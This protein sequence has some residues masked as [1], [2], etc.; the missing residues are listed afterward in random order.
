M[1]DVSLNEIAKT[2]R[3]FACNAYEGTMSCPDGKSGAVLYERMKHPLIGDLVVEWSSAT[4]SAVDSHI[5]AVGY[6]LHQDGASYRIR[7]LD[8]RE[9]EWS[10][11][12]FIAI[13]EN[14][15]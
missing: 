12:F 6:L 8:G 1:T 11:A 9:E 5:N 3:L 14:P 13:V 15:I 10:N 4:R 2:L 7:T